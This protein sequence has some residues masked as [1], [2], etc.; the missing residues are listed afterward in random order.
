MISNFL[1]PLLAPMLTDV[2]QPSLG[3]CLAEM[4]VWAKLNPRNI[5]LGT[6][7]RNCPSGIS[8][9]KHSVVIADRW[10]CS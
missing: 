4:E 2:T 3:V 5:Y 6:W 9:H 8:E 10:L 7:S 1:L